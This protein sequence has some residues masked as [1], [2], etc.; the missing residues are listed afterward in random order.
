MGNACKLQ[1]AVGYA[2][3]VLVRKRERTKE[4][5]VELK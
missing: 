3:I 1:K 2:V 4:S 5:Q